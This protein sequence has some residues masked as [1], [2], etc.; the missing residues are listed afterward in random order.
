MTFCLWR[1]FW[2]KST[3][4]SIFYKTIRCYELGE[5]TWLRG[6]L[7]F[8][9]QL[10]KYWV[11][12]GRLKLLNIN[13]M[14]WQG[15]PI[16]KCLPRNV[17]CGENIQKYLHLNTWLLV[18]SYWLN[19]TDSKFVSKLL[20]TEVRPQVVLRYQEIYFCCCCRYKL[21][22][23]RKVGPVLTLNYEA[24]I[25]KCVSHTQV[26]RPFYSSGLLTSNSFYCWSGEVKWKSCV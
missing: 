2:N 16:I 8:G 10:H 6:W 15:G 14:K 11:F 23:T 13:M 22:V 19:N 5:I 9:I 3:L 25:P 20:N 12:R 24:G 26:Y 1:C 7:S 4:K 18:I 21:D 17:H